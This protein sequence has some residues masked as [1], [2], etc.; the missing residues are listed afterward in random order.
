MW[1]LYKFALKS[2]ISFEKIQNKPK[3]VEDLNQWSV[4]YETSVML[5]QGY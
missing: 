5:S 2:N 4:T 1:E 3:F